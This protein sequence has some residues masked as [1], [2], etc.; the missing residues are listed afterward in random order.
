MIHGLGS[1]G[2]LAL[3]QSQIVAAVM[4]QLMQQ[5]E[6]PEPSLDLW[7]PENAADAELADCIALPEPHHLNDVVTTLEQQALRGG[8]DFVGK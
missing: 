1:H 7:R 2:S 3:K 6:A 4:A 8:A 5:Q